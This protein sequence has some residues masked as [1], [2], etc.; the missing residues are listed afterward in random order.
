[1][2]KRLFCKH[3]FNN[4]QPY[5]ICIFGWGGL[6]N[7]ELRKIAKCEHCGKQEDVF[8][9][10]T[11]MYEAD[12]YLSMLKSLGYISVEELNARKAMK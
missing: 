1:M 3:K 2:F 8:I 12:L 5:Y 6:V 4:A 11:S 10:K 7:F 9:M